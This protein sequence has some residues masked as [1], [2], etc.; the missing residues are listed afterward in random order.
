MAESQYT[1]VR[2][3]AALDCT[4]PVGR[5][6]YCFMHHQRL[7]RHGALDLPVKRK[8]PTLLDRFWEKVDRSGGPL[9][10]W[11]WLGVV[12]DNGYGKL[13]NRYAH[14][15]AYQ[16]AVGPIPDGLTIDHVKARGCTRRDCC[17][18]AHLEPVT[19][20]ENALR[21]DSRNARNARK[22]HCRRGHEFTPENTRI[23]KRGH[24]EC[25]TCSRMNRAYRRLDLEGIGN[26]RTLAAVMW[27]RRGRARARRDGD[28]D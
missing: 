22:T 9:A 25:R 21:G 24:R 12:S 16:L 5:A 11:P 20:G 10:C 2:L 1:P 15:V 13:N 19:R 3:C 26:P 6:Q 7:R 8:R 4:K 17:N 28:D 27:D 18:P 23:S 14:R